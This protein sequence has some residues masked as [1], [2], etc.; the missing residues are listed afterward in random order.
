MASGYST[1]LDSTLGTTTALYIGGSSSAY[2][3][4]LVEIS[5]WHSIYGLYLAQAGDSIMGLMP[6]EDESI[7]LVLVQKQN[8]RREKKYV[9]TRPH[10]LEK[11]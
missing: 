3:L 10:G 9:I 6:D 8:D 11:K 1:R 2:Y 7:V 5:R 4:T